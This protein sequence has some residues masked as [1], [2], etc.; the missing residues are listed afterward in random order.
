MRSRWWSERGFGMTEL[1]VVVALIGVLAALGVPNM[2]RYWQTSTLAAGADEFAGVLSRARALAVTQNTTVCVQVTGTSVRFVIPT[3]AGTVWTG[4]GTDAAGVIR[5]SSS[6]E[7]SNPA[8][9][10]VIFTSTGGANPQGSYTVT[11]PKDGKTRSVQV[12][13]TGRVL[14]Q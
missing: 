12:L 3:C 9:V 11:N 8:N 7:I 2:L 1:I 5:L 4:T 10:M 13:T 14:Q 6:L